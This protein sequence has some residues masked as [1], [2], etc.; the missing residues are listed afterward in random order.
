[1]WNAYTTINPALPSRDIRVRDL[2]VDGSINYTNYSTFS[3][4]VTQESGTT[5]VVQIAV[6]KIG[7]VIN[8]YIPQMSS[9]AVFTQAFKSI[10]IPVAYRP[11]VSGLAQPVYTSQNNVKAVGVAVFDAVTN[12]KIFTKADQ[13][14]P[15]NSVDAISYPCV[16][17]YLKSL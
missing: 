12:L 16:V 11:A 17:S 4:T 5:S 1:M 9:N 10:P 14:A 3:A 2:T 6:L 7:D 13:S 8:L 15:T